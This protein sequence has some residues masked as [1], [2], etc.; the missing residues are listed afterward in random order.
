MVKTDKEN[1]L[2]KQNKIQSVSTSET[3]SKEKKQSKSSKSSTVTIQDA[4]NIATRENSSN[5]EENV[6]ER[7]GKG[8]RK[9]GN[10][11]KTTS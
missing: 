2:N 3:F 1:A 7:N 8:R 6:S 4:N 11:N 9:R 10:H 5:G